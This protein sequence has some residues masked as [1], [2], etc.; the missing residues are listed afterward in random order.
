VQRAPLEVRE[1]HPRFQA[2]LQLAAAVVESLTAPRLALRAGPVAVAAA[3][4]RAQVLPEV[5][6]PRVREMLAGP[7]QSMCLL[8]AVVAAALVL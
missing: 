8:L 1:T 6:E 4:L 5:L 3:I 7:A 2:S